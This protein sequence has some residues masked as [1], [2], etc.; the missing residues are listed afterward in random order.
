MRRITAILML[1]LLPLGAQQ[2]PPPAQAQPPAQGFKFSATAQLVVEIVT[3]K[4]KNGNPIEGLTA[5]DC[6]ITENGKP[7]TVSFCEFQKVQ[8]I[9][10]GGEPAPA[11]PPT[12]AANVDPVTR[13]QIQ[14]EQPG[15]IRYRD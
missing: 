13:H 4:D 15:D 5:K 8:E 2:A 10:E 11:A 14:A 12:V 3:A 6:L 9:A 1:A 7:Q